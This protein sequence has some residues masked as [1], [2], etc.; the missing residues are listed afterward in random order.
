M[1]EIKYKIE[2]RN[3]GWYLATADLNRGGSII[4]EAE[5]YSSL[6]EKILGFTQE[7]LEFCRANNVPVPENPKIKLLYSELFSNNHDSENILI[8]GNPEGQGYRAVSNSNLNLNMYN[9]DFDVLREELLQRIQE[10]VNDRNVEFRLEE[11]LD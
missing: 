4:V 2:K 10:S 11:V 5:T 1:E 6:K 8:T 7:H 9:E 3:D